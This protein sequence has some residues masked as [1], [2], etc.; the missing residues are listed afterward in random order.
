MWCPLDA[1]RVSVE[2]YARAVE[3]AA[4]RL[5]ELRQEEWQA[6]GLAVAALGLSV[7]ATRFRPSLAVPLLLGGFGVVTLGARAAFRRWDLLERLSGDR[8][9]YTIAEVHEF[10]ARQTTLERRRTF[11][12]L[13]RSKLIEPVP[14]RILVSF[15][16]LEAL[17]SELED[18]DLELDT[19][20]A[21]ACKRL[22]SDVE[23]PLLDP[24]G[25]AGD[26]RSRVRQIR[27]GFEAR[28]VDAHGLQS[29]HAA[30]T[31]P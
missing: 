4:A 6:F 20:C 13:I 1:R 9:A 19:A 16:E 23:S 15:Q 21:V 30:A 29:F 3:D 18:A 17:A 27:F 26:L 28:P 2:M 7:A 31:R 12:A 22:L 11:A 5:R 14:A 25:S 24:T 8:D 10:A